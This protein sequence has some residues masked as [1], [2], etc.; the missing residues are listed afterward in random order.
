M[1]QLF[2]IFQPIL[3]YLLNPTNL[4]NLSI[5]NCFQE[6]STVG[7]YDKGKIRYFLKAFLKIRFLSCA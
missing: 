6:V 7:K 3:N 1:W 2:F 4:S 5:F